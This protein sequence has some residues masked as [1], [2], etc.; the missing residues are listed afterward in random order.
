MLMPLTQLRRQ[1]PLRVNLVLVGGEHTGKTLLARKLL[2][3]DCG[4]DLAPA[5][6]IGL[7]FA[8]RPMHLAEV[9]RTVRLH[10]WDTSGQERFRVLVDRKISDL[11]R[12]DVVVAVYDVSARDTFDAISDLMRRVLPVAARLSP[13]LAIVGNKAHVEHGKRAVSE[14]EGRAK[15]SELGAAVFFESACLA[16]GC[17]D[18]ADGT[19]SVEDG[20]L[21]PVLRLCAE[22]S[23]AAPPT[24]RAK[25]PPCPVQLPAGASCREEAAVQGRP[26]ICTAPLRRCLGLTA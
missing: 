16:A 25:L 7:D 20:L 14:A 17:A 8:V 12:H 5:P 11:A 9:G 19:T 21:R 24:P 18:G 1:S 23:P 10:V 22:A 4:S 6:T 13:Q 26:W 15:A 2:A 3:Q